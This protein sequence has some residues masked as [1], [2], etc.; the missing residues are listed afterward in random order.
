MAGEVV[1]I[2][3]GTGIMPCLLSVSTVRKHGERTLVGSYV[4]AIGELKASAEMYELIT[5]KLFIHEDPNMES[6]W[7]TE[8][9]QQHKREIE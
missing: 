9:A 8:V 7:M 1:I 3:D 5:H 4:Q 6:L 2:D